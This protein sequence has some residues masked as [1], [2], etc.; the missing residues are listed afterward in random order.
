AEISA[1]L[2]A[3]PPS[4]LRRA[5][6]L[7]ALLNLADGLDGTGP[8]AGTAHEQPPANGTGHTDDTA[9]LADMAVD[10]LVRMA[11]GGDRD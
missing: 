10:D 11:L 7:D 6:L 2:A 8:A 3:I 4:A 5:G 1:R 9:D